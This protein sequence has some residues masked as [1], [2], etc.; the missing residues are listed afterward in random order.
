MPRQRGSK[1]NRDG[2][3]DLLGNLDLGPTPHEVLWE[4]LKARGLL[5]GDDPID[6]S[7][8]ALRIPLGVEVLTLLGF[9]ELSANR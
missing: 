2:V 8:W 1:A 3:P 4:V 6:P 9:E 5:V 7:T